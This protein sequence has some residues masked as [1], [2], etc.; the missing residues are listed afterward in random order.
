MVPNLIPVVMF[1][2]LLGAGAATLS[3][4]T[5]LIGCAA[6]G[7]AIDDTAHFLVAY[8]QHRAE[9]WAPHEAAA[10]CTRRIGRPIVATSMML[11]AGFLVLTLSGFATIREFGGLSAAV[12][13]VCLAA[14]LTLLPA[15]LTKAKV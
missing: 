13:L 6:L 12:M 10:L 7:I 1:F 4:P 11:V 5:S 8:R 2:G 14:D 15:I 3:L 9:G